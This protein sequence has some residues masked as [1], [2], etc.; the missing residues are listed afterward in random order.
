MFVVQRWV[1]LEKRWRIFLYVGRR[2]E[3]GRDDYDDDGIIFVVSKKKRMYTVNSQVALI[4]FNDFWG[5]FFDGLSTVNKG[6]H[7]FCKQIFE[8]VEICR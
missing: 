7:G 1:K 8:H 3:D 5:C 6:V 2:F 4:G